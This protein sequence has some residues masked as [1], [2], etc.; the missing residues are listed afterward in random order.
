MPTPETILELAHAIRPYL[1]DL[2][3]SSTATELD[4]ALAELLAQADSNSSIYL[5]IQ[6]RLREH[7]TTREW[8]EKFLEDQS[9]ADQHRT[10]NPLV[11]QQ[12]PVNAARFVCPQCDHTW[13]RPSVGREPP[14]CPI[15]NISL[16]RAP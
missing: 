4:Q 13:F 9:F 11:G 14:P 3:P 8:A 5:L 1:P 2:L 7:P 15:H 6:K 12:S 16:Q 10:Y